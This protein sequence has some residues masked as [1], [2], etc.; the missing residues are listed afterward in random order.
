VHA[1]KDFLPSLIEAVLFLLGVSLVLAL[2]AATWGLI[3]K[4]RLKHFGREFRAMDSGLLLLFLIG[5]GTIAFPAI[6]AVGFRTDMPPIW[7]LQGLFV[8]AI[9][10]VG[11]TSYRIE[12]FYTVNLAV[13]VIAIAAAS[14]FVA[15]PLHALYRNDH[16][17][18]EGRNFYHQAA[19]ELTGRW[20]RLSGEALT[21]VGGDDVLAFAT[22]FYSPDHPVYDERLA[23]VNPEPLPGPEAFERGWA[24]MCFHADAPCIA[25]MESIAARASYFVRFEFELQ[26]ALLGQPG[27]TERFTALMVP[28]SSEQEIVPSPATSSAEDFSAARRAPSQAN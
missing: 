12:R 3:V 21:A 1:G 6:T 28:P 26:S 18:H 22:A 9:R 14:A 17:L 25:K 4:D 8:F 15:A 20:H 7:A 23:L 13:F 2:P 19:L 10:V 11:S 5:A 24:A 27:A 16:P